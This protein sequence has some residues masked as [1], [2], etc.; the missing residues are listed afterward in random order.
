MRL[1]MA[2]SDEMADSLLLSD[3]RVVDDLRVGDFTPNQLDELLRRE[4]LDAGDL[5][6]DLRLLL[7]K[8]ILA[9]VFLRLRPSPNTDAP[10]TEYQ[11]FDS[12]WRRI[13]INAKH[14]D[15][16]SVLSLADKICD[17]QVHPLPRRTAIDAGVSETTLE[18]LVASGWIATGADGRGWLLP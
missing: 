10:D 8:P 12:F 11:V 18:R 5:A 14:A 6:P 15:F 7:R 13:A 9:G 2:V 16:G 17:A 1:V 4:G 3:A